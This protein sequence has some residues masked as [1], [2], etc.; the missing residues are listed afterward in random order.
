[1]RPV[2][3][4]A[5]LLWSVDSFADDRP[6]IIVI[7]AD[8][9]GY[10]DLGCFGATEIETPHLDRMAKE[11]RRFTDFYSA[12]PTCTP[13]RAGLLTGC[14]PVRAGFGDA[15]AVQITHFDVFE[16]T[17]RRLG[18]GFAQRRHHGVLGRELLVR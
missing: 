13:S 5:L 6:N 8:D 12:G 15:I 14:Y 16:W 18:R 4:I 11:G 2:V 10:N 17:W 9:L 1:M 7:F 3:L